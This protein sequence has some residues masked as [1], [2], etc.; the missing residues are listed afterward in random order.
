ME[1]DRERTSAAVW[2]WGLAAV[3]VA[4]EIIM[5]RWTASEA[6]VQALTGADGTL[7]GALATTPWA[8]WALA[9]VG[10]AAAVLFALRKLPVL[11]GLLALVPGNL[12]IQAHGYV[13]YDYERYFFPS[14]ALMLG[15]VLGLLW[16]RALGLRSSTA[17]AQLD[18][19]GAQGA[20]AMLGAAYVSAGL[21][22]LLI[23]GLGWSHTH[24]IQLTLMLYHP[25]DVDWAVDPM[26]ELVVATP[27]MA[28]AMAAGTVVLELAA[29]LMPF[30]R[31]GRLVGGLGL[32][33]FHAGLFLLTRIVFIQSVCL[34]ALFT[35]EWG[36]MDA[37]G[38]RLAVERARLRRMA[39]AWAAGAALLVMGVV[40][41]GVEPHEQVLPPVALEFQYIDPGWRRVEACGPLRVGAQLGGGWQVASLQ[42]RD[43][44][45]R[46]MLWRPDGG[47]VLFSMAPGRA[48]P[49]GPYDVGALGLAHHPSP[50]RVEEFD[51]AARV[52]AG[53]VRSAVGQ[54]D[55]VAT[56][57]AWIE[58][59]ER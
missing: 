57:A 3:F 1:G 39:A 35:F 10:S 15:W 11:F 29:F 22:K 21:S 53:I 51:L 38:A 9:A 37:L 48:Q 17:G 4:D 6:K 56:A 59:C 5:A 27:W 14:G 52:L 13:Y 33:A 18:R 34:I 20:T 50:V 24:V 47:F 31:R 44:Q 8:L 26:W 30:G 28:E 41:S 23:G 40:A 16:G 46:S 32:L 49:S 2:R 25:V 55:P 45:L 43:G 42:V 12:L 19:L 7:V 58:E 36:A 54:G